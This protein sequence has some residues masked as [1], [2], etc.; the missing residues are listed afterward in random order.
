MTIWEPAFGGSH[1]LSPPPQ[2]AYD[3]RGM[4]EVLL[5]EAA[6][7]NHGADAEVQIALQIVGDLAIGT[8]QNWHVALVGTE[9]PGPVNLVIYAF[10]RR[11]V[12]QA[13]DPVGL[14]L[15]AHGGFEPCAA[16]F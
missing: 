8:H 16:I 1:T 10:G 14:G 13:P 3:D 5:A 15:L 11:K 12:G 6:G 4:L 2:V 7:Q 9:S